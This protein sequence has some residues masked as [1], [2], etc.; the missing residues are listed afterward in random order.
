MLEAGGEPSATNLVLRNKPNWTAVIFL[1]GLGA[2]HLT[3]WAIATTHEKPEAYMSLVFGLAFL[4]ASVSCYLVRFEVM[5]IPSERRL[6]LRTGYSRFRVE[7]S[8]PFS[9]I[10]AVRLT[11]TPD[12]DHATGRVELLCHN[13]NIACPPTSVAR[14]EALCLAVTIGVR[15]VKV[16]DGRVAHVRRRTRATNMDQLSA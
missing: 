13:E 10:H 16:T 15:L 5:V 1:A 12:P 6:R 8:I 11:L 7:R 3:V 9:E 4:L 2:L 14:V